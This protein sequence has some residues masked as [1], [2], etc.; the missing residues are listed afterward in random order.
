M[1]SAPAGQ[2]ATRARLAT[3]T[4][5][6]STYRFGT[7]MVRY[8]WHPL[9]GKE[10]RITRRIHSGG[11][12]YIHVDVGDDL[13]HE[14][15]AWMFDPVVCGAMDVG[16]PVVAVAGLQELRRV[17]LGGSLD[18]SPTLGKG[19]VNEESA[20][21]TGPKALQAV[22]QHGSGATVPDAADGGSRRDRKRSYRCARRVAARSEQRD[23]QRRK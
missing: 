3:Q 2:L 14:I 20:Q 15:P 18:P 13:S 23:K 5:S 7:A 4:K 6:H 16:P 19:S 8:E 22:E 1:K 12:D 21:E 17:L 11:R 10:V 9:A